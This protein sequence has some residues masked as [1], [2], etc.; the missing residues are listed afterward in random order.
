MPPDNSSQSEHD[1]FLVVPHRVSRGSWRLVPPIFLMLLAIGVFG[2][3]AGVSDWHWQWPSWP[4]PKPTVAS[5][6]PKPKPA[7]N[8][9]ASKRTAD[10][11]PAAKPESSPK[12]A[13]AAKADAEKQK[14]IED[15]QKEAD[16]IKQQREELA[17][18][19]EREGEKIASAP[20][21]APIFGRGNPAFVVQQ[22][23]QMEAMMREAMAQHQRQVEAMFREHRDFIARNDGMNRGAP[24]QFGEFDRAM[25]QMRS[26]M[27][28]FERE[29]RDMMRRNDRPFP[30]PPWMGF[31]VPN[32]PLPG[33]GDEIADQEDSDAPRVRRYE[34]T[35]RNGNRV[36]GIEIR[37]G[38]SR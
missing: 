12:L 25:E 35:D 15:I 2:L 11:A 13:D 28:A 3:R 24:D 34:F 8:T 29:A 6:A 14:A 19:K 21:P 31:G 1:D 26:E 36:R 20:R 17:K 23:A 22:R 4:K 18:I 30:Q 32:P 16:R 5:A 7:P 27:R 37:R 9:P 33:I 10:A 38:F